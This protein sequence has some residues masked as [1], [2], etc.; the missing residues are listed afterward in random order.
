MLDFI[1]GIFSVIFQ[2]NMR[3]HHDI[4]FAMPLM[5]AAITGLIIGFTIL[6]WITREQKEMCSEKNQREDD[7]S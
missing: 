6:S 3:D 7:H 4:P 1:L 5:M 2:M